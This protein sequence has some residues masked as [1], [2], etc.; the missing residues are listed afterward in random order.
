MITTIK[1]LLG[2]LLIWSS[3]FVQAN[4]PLDT[5][6]LRCT[7]VGSNGNVSLFWQT[8]NDPFNVFDHYEIFDAAGN[9]LGTVNNRLTGQFTVVGANADIA[10]RDYYVK[11]ISTNGGLYNSPN[12]DTLSS[13][14]LIVTNLNNGKAELIW[15]AIHNP[16]LP[17]SSGWYMVYKS[18]S[19]GPWVL[20]DSMPYGQAFYTDTIYSCNAQIDYRIEIADQ[21]GCGSVSNTDGEQFEDILPPYIPEITYTT[22]DT[23]NGN[24]FI[25]WNQNAAPDTDGYIVLQNQGGGWVILDTVYGI[26]NTTY[27]NT[28]SNADNES[29]TY[30][31]VA[32][33]DCWSGTPLTPNTTPV[34]T[35][36][37][38][39]YLE[40]NLDICGQTIELSWNEYI[41]WPGGVASYELWYQENNDPYQLL[42][43]Y[44]GNNLTEVQSVNRGSDYCY[45]VKAI[46]DNGLTSLSN[47]VC[48]FIQAP[49][50]PTYNYLQ[51]ATVNNSGT[52]T[53][54]A[55][56][57]QTANLSKLR[58]ERAT[59]ASG[60]YKTAAI[61]NVVAN[62]VSLTDSNVNTEEQSYYYRVLAVDSCGDIA[63]V[64]NPGRTILLEVFPNNEELEVDLRWNAYDQWDG[65]VAGYRIYRGIDGVFDPNPIVTLFPSAR[66]YV[67]DVSEFIDEPGEFC[68]YIEAFEN[69]NSYGID[70]V[71]YSN[72]ACAYLEP[73]VWVPN[74]MVIGG[75][76]NEFKPSMSYINF[77]DYQM[78]IY[79]RWGEV[80]F[81]TE[82]IQEGWD[83]RYH[84][85]YVKSGVYVYHILYSSA[86]GK[87]FEKRGSVT[88]V[89]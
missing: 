48:R 10:S 12:S 73:L 27:Y 78:Y 56:V 36:H 28:N 87:Y 77:N 67:D 4:Q 5:P 50:T 34:G 11:A 68:Y 75:V 62:P 2:L 26:G 58:L 63:L 3:I 82:D 45:V 88:V 33:D 20:M 42:G 49:T 70:E 25:E 38:T 8:I 59:S 51:T 53:I 66:E 22:V 29:E 57:D 80:I 86:E 32:F 61:S 18:I 16:E 24:T 64:S 65:N 52:V 84:S 81:K 44:S 41:T 31:I 35:A 23:T 39:I 55:R 1:Y 76:N 71:S 47:K 43:T 37:N 14:F 40:Q 83:G 72:N 46:G 74:A 9:S 15:N 7:A 19:A 6:G 17:S 79:N 13:I 89:K 85:N 21:S 30:A 60:P 54:R 69:P